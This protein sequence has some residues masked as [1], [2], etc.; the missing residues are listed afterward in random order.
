ME[1]HDQNH[2][3]II[4]LRQT[5]KNFLASQNDYFMDKIDDEAMLDYT[6]QGFWNGLKIGKRRLKEAGLRR[7]IKISY[8][9]GDL[10]LWTENDGGNT[11]AHTFADITTTRIYYKDDEKI[12]FE[13]GKDCCELNQIQYTVNGDEA[14]C[15]QCGHVG[16]ISR[17][18]DGCDYC[19]TS[20]RVKDFEPK[21][22]TWTMQ[23][24]EHQRIWNY[25]KK[26]V[27]IF[28]V[29]WAIIAIVGIFT[30]A[31]F[32]LSSLMVENGEYE[33]AERALAQWGSVEVAALMM[34]L[35]PIGI[36]CMGYGFFI[37]GIVMLAYIMKTKM[38]IRDGEIIEDE[39]PDF[40][41]EDF[42]Q[43]LEFKLKH[44]YMAKKEKDVSAYIKA[45]VSDFIKDHANV[46]DCLPAF[47]FE[48]ITDCG[49]YYE[50]NVIAAVKL[51]VY[52]N[53]KIRIRR[54]RLN[55]TLTG[56]KDMALSTSKDVIKPFL[57]ENCGGSI[58]I[59]TDHVC[60]HCGESYDYSKH[61]WQIT[62]I[63]DGGKVK[64]IY[65]NS[66]IA[67]IIAFI[68]V[69]LLTPAIYLKK[70][71]SNIHSLFGSNY[72]YHSSVLDNPSSDIYAASE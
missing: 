13:K 18:I 22:S 9:R 72:S 4:Q 32:F 11:R 65:R 6:T 42:A 23:E 62:D 66:I 45:D 44:L 51:Y 52:Q 55:L 58:D 36:H 5:A 37:I 56:L 70:N 33:A 35:T 49:T 20:F 3:V 38:I 69:T 61:G 27:P 25:W 64:N 50:M 59:Y 10:S 47:N 31:D 34:T 48:N 39:I 71:E 15:P 7:E 57:C 26:I 14:P 67:M 17:F 12:Y 53:G 68:L 1:I 54:E 41:A 63:A 30:G 19:G 29:I 28:F 40:S 8:D 43:D 60:K 2:P 21:I 24:R 16:K 46:I